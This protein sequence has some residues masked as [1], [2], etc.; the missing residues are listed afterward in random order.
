MNTKCHGYTL[1]G[2]EPKWCGLTA[3][4]RCTRGPF[5]S[6][7]RR[8][9][10][11]HFINRRREVHTQHTTHHSHTQ[12]LEPETDVSAPQGKATTTKP[13]GTL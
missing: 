13:Y 4:G 3:A 7:T 5:F 9:T 10:V 6:R 2:L 8:I 1:G 11:Y 12:R